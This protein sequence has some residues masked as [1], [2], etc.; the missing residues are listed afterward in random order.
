[1]RL[2]ISTS[3]S[4]LSPRE[5]GKTLKAAGLKS[6]VFPLDSSAPESL[7]E[8]YVEA[9]SENDL[10]IAEVGIW[11]NA[12]ARDEKERLENLKYSINQLLLADK[13]KARCCVNVAGSSGERWDG[14]YASNYSFDTYKKTVDMVRTVIDEA[15][16]RNT[17]FT[18]EPMPWMLPDGPDEYLQ[19]IETVGRDRFAVHMDIINMINSPKRFFF[20]ED[21][22]EEVFEKLGNRIRSCHLKDIRLLSEYTFML[23]ECAPG[24]GTFNFEKYVELANKY[25]PQMPMIIEHM[26]SDEAYFENVKYF[27]NRIK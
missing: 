17:Y 15:K 13:V 19:L 21:F 22:L 4:N 24:E 27:T 2:G 14:G 1:M 10:M 11:K 6:V 26:S 3:L 8:E 9:A 12:I 5:W 7:I 25:D 23:R 16:P 18:L 20:Q